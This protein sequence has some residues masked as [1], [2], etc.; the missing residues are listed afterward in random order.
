MGK[1]KK[2]NKK[3]SVK[4]Y[5]VTERIRALYLDPVTSLLFDIRDN[6][7]ISK[8]E[9]I[10]DINKL[11]SDYRFL[12]KYKIND[13]LGYLDVMSADALSKLTAATDEN[14]C[15]F[16]KMCNR[17]IRESTEIFTCINY[18]NKEKSFIEHIMQTERCMGL[19]RPQIKCTTFSISLIVNISLFSSIMRFCVENQLLAFTEYLCSHQFIIDYLVLNTKSL[20]KKDAMLKKELN[21][22]DEVFVEICKT[23]SQ[24]DYL[25]SEAAGMIFLD[26]LKYYSECI[27]ELDPN[28]SNEN[29]NGYLKVVH[30]KGNS[31]FFHDQDDIIKFIE[32]HI[33]VVEEIKEYPELLEKMPVN[34]FADRIDADGDRFLCTMD[35]GVEELSNQEMIDEIEEHIDIK[36]I[37]LNE[38][39]N[40]EMILV[41]AYRELCNDFAA[42]VAM[43]MIFSDIKS[44][45]NK[46]IERLKCN[47]SS[48]K[49]RS[50]DYKNYARKLRKKNNELEVNI[51]G[52]DAESVERLK[53]Q[54][55]EQSAL[56]SDLKKENVDLKNQISLKKYKTE[57][58][59][60]KISSLE[61]EIR[62]LKNRIALMESLAE[63]SDDEELKEKSEQEIIEELNDENLTDE[64]YSIAKSCKMAFFVPVW[65]NSVYLQNLFPNS[66]FIKLQE[67]T[68]FDIGSSVDGVVICTKGTKHATYYKILNQCENY[69]LQYVPVS[70]YGIK[71]MSKAAINLLKSLE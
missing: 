38:E 49:Q 54:I 13:L 22:S 1:K 14:M 45:Y 7:S 57:K 55:S 6:K 56:I 39:Q 47:L 20:N 25:S 15:A 48:E 41:C 31:I 17:F 67:D 35:V 10:T 44:D 68:N 3:K 71:R 16:D 26:F 43:A 46:K 64:D 59:D 58:K 28:A 5:D 12:G 52:M 23:T 36:E 70:S 65:V 24:R 61:E 69:N 37:I 4:M 27:K 33:L 62:K 51:K 9:N 63:E 18:Y 19:Y 2:M 66:K 50:S 53:I 40:I 29:L 11:L 60:N 30:E 8:K 32:D 42:H 21:M 34:F